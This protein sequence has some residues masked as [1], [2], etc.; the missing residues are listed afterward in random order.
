MQEKNYMATR[1]LGEKGICKGMVK[2]GAKILLYRKKNKEWKEPCMKI[3]LYRAEV[4][5]AVREEK[6]RE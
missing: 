2:T 4:V 1:F 6:A 3:S 5:W